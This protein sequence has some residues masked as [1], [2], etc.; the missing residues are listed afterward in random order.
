MSVRPCSRKEFVLLGEVFVGTLSGV[1][2]TEARRSPAPK[3][4]YV[5][6]LKGRWGATEQGV[7]RALLDERLERAGFPAKPNG[8]GKRRP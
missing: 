4:C 2:G 3:P 6:E 7:C 8:K 1:P 5:Q